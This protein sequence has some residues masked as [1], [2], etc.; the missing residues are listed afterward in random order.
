MLQNKEANVQNYQKMLNQNTKKNPGI[1]FAL[2]NC[3]GEMGMDNFGYLSNLLYN[4]T[5]KKFYGVRTLQLN[6]P[7][8][9]TSHCAFSWTTPHPLPPSVGTLWMTPNRNQNLH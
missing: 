2:F 3:K 4:E 5:V 8:S 7:F 6:F 9:H 1:E